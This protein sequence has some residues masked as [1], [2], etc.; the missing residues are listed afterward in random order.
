MNWATAPPP[1]APGLHSEGSGRDTLSPWDKCIAPSD[2][3]TRLQLVLRRRVRFLSGVPDKAAE[4]GSAHGL[5]GYKQKRQLGEGPRLLS[6][7]GAESPRLQEPSRQPGA[8]V[9]GVR[10]EQGDAKNCN[11]LEH[12]RSTACA[13]R[14]IRFLPWAI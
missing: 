1:C 7:S 5:R 10:G 12:S 4:Q 3:D 9:P 2:R 13:R 6:P 8:C 11:D 14:H